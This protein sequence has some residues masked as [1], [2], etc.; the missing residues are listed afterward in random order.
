M[1]HSKVADLKKG[2][3]KITFTVYGEKSWG[4]EAFVTDYIKFSP[5]K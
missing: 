5:I 1:R 2:I 4:Y 3:N